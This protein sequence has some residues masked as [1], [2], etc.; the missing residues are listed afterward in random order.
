MPQTIKF[1]YATLCYVCNTI[2]RYVIPS[3]LCVIGIS[4]LQQYL[5]LPVENKFVGDYLVF[6][7]IWLK[8]IFWQWQVT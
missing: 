5:S 7:K 6:N 8:E 1:W 2:Q 3:N 4:K